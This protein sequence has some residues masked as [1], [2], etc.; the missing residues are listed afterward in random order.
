MLTIISECDPLDGPDNIAKVTLSYYGCTA[1][2]VI[3][4]RA[5]PPYRDMRLTRSSASSYHA[6][7]ISKLDMKLRCLHNTYEH[8]EESSPSAYNLD[9]PTAW[10]IWKRRIMFPVAILFRPKYISTRMALAI[11]IW[12]Q[13]PRRISKPRWRAIFYRASRATELPGSNYKNEHRLNVHH[14]CRKEHAERWLVN[15]PTS[16]NATLLTPPPSK[17]DKIEHNSHHESNLEAVEEIHHTA[18][19]TSIHHLWA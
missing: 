1:N 9:S 18:A 5:P 10:L 19:R 8:K 2:T 6:P 14:D 7:L 17:L 12:I 15:L 16:A 13:R 3:P 4:L 11:A